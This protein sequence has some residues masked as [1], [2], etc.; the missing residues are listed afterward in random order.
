MTNIC[1]INNVH[2]RI[3]RTFYI[4]VDYRIMLIQN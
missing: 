4:V 2:G 1:S 3:Q